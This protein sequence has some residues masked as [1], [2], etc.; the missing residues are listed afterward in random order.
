MDPKQVIRSNACCGRLDRFAV[1]ASGE[2]GSLH[3]AKEEPDGNQATIA[4][5]SCCSSGDDTTDNGNRWKVQR[6]LSDLVQEVFPA[7]FCWLG[8]T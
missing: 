6:R 5:S 7:Q 3:E 2:I 1:L 4:L 8:L